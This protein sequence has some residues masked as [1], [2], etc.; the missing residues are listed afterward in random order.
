MQSHAGG[1]NRGGGTHYVCMNERIY[2]TLNSNSLGS[3]HECV[4][5]GQTEKMCL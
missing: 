4:P 2:N 3:S 1:S 5:V